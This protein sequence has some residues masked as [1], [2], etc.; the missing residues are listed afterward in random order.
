MTV[1][2]SKMDEQHDSDNNSAADND[3]DDIY[4]FGVGP[5]VNPQVRKRHRVQV[6]QEQPAVLPDFRLTFNYGGIANVVQQRGY[7]VHGI[8][9]KFESRQEWNGFVHTNVGNNLSKLVKVY[10]YKH[11]SDQLN[12][13]NHKMDGRS[14]YSDEEEDEFPDLS[15][16]MDILDIDNGNKDREYIEAYVF[17]I[18]PEEFKHDDLDLPIEQLPSERYLRLIANGM[19]YYN[20]N[21]EYVQDQIMAIGFVP[22][23][24]PDQYM[25]FET[26][27]PLPKIPYRKYLRICENSFESNKKKQ[28]RLYFVLGKYVFEML[29][30]ENQRLNPGTEWVLEFAHGKPDIVLILHKLLV[31]PDIPVVDTQ[32]ELTPLHYAWAENHSVEFLSK[33]GLTAKRVYELL[34]E[35]DY[36]TQER[37]LWRWCCR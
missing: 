1:Q 11:D 5:I 20:I 17:H 32:E 19:S 7:D 12:K 9:M 24:T 25:K 36:A 22:K 16:E 4:Y 34:E 29:V 13:K 37:C 3:Q 23:R 35:D 28:S 30:S 14:E 33:C 15:Q 6:S 8:V 31:D 27:P 21:P 26:V 18:R 10:P 2:T